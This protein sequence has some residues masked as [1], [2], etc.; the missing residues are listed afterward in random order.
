MKK[1]L[2]K[3]FRH[4]R[5]FLKILVNKATAGFKV[6][7]RMRII[8]KQGLIWVPAYI[9]MYY[10]FNKLLLHLYIIATIYKEEELYM[11]I[12]NK[13]TTIEATT[14][15]ARFDDVKIE[16]NSNID[17]RLDYLVIAC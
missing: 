14:T 8:N 1:S 15:V 2:I 13:T 7:W 9:I 3:I 10:F 5:V 12:E 6:C 11:D 16:L 17:M 4:Y